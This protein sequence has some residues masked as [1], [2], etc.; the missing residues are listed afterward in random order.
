MRCGVAVER[1]RRRLAGHAVQ[2]R[3]R[4]LDGR[5]RLLRL[6]DAVQART[7]G[8]GISP[9]CYL[10]AT[11]RAARTPGL[12]LTPGRALAWS[13]PGCEM[14]SPAD[15]G[16]VA[17]VGRRRVSLCRGLMNLEA[18][19]G[20]PGLESHDVRRVRRVDHVIADPEFHALAWVDLF[21]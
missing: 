20:L 17:A 13:A 12:R 7:R 9:E 6:L 21:F 14:P 8:D 10:G 1:S 19:A 15:A 11:P 18:R 2:R 5:R 4:E 16:G 3:I